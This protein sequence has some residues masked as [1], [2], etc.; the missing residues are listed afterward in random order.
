ME[1]IDQNRFY[2]SALYDFAY[3]E[4]HFIN[5]S[6]FRISFEVRWRIIENGLPDAI[7]DTVPLPDLFHH[8]QISHAFIEKFLKYLISIYDK[9]ITIEEL[10]KFKHNINKLIIHTK[11][12]NFDLESNFEKNEIILLKTISEMNFPHLRYSQPQIFTINF[13]TLKSLIQKIFEILR[14]IRFQNTSSITKDEQK[15]KRDGRIFGHVEKKIAPKILSMSRFEKIITS[16]KL[17]NIERELIQK[18]YQ[19]TDSEANLVSEEDDIQLISAIEKTGEELWDF[20]EIR[21]EIT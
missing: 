14:R 10:I 15:N 4:K 6:G 16:D 9:E 11:K 13:R 8:L 18:S 1:K 17:S 5:S 21:F 2:V 3:L 19:I 7:T 12:L 20:G